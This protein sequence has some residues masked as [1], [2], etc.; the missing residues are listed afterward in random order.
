MDELWYMVMKFTNKNNL[1]VWLGRHFEEERRAEEEEKEL[2]YF[3]TYF[4]LFVFEINFNAYKWH[5]IS[6]KIFIVFNRLDICMDIRMAIPYG[7]SCIFSSFITTM[8][9]NFKV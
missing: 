2:I 3:S 6:L 5:L 1:Y 7:Y 4:Y 8:R 9:N